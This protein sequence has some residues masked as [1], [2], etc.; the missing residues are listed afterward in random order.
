M[1]R[2]YIVIASRN[3]VRQKGYSLINILGLSIGL[4][5]FIMIVMFVMHELSYDKFHEKSDRIYRVCVDG[6]I[7]GDAFHVAVSAAPTGPAM[8]REFP[9]VIAATRID[10]LPQSVLFSYEESKI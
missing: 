9:E 4:A 2:N 10:R 5:A 8:V 6:L 3:L 7:A 1:L